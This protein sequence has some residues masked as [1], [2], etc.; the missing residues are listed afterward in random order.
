M[1][2]RR[3]FGELE[4]R[5]GKSGTVSYRARYALADGTRFSR[6]FATKLDADAWLS[7]ERSLLDKGTWTTPE[8]RRLV[9]DQQAMAASLNTVGRFAERYLQER[10]LRPTTAHGYRKLLDNRILPTFADVPL[11]EVRLIDIT[12]WLTGLPTD[13]ESS[14]AAAYRLLRSILEAAEEEELIDRAPPKVR[15]AATARVKKKARPASFAELQVIVGHMPDHSSS[16][17]SS[18][19][20]SDFAR[21]S[22]PSC[23]VATSTST[24][25]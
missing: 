21:E 14:N 5:V 13:T 12:T 7:A 24:P 17:S 6:T 1:T 22:C 16:S 3:A 20:S 8:A 15:G 2:G 10:P 11:R 4:R 18:P 25:D 19:G 23:A 9:Q